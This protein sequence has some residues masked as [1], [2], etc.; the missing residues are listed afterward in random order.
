MGQ[1][2]Q[3]VLTKKT[4]VKRLSD[5]KINFLRHILIVHVQG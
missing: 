1:G 4:S 5:Q 2:L 3:H